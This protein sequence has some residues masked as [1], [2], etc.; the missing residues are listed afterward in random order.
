MKYI[1]TLGETGV[2]VGDCRDG[3]SVRFLLVALR[4]ARAVDA[5]V[6]RGTKRGF[7]TVHKKY[8]YNISSPIL[9]RE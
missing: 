6:A 9:F 7:E 4:A 3:S 5:A 8:V 1:L 2:R